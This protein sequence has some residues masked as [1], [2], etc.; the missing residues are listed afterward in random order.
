M[1]VAWLMAT[2]AG[3]G[4][5]LWEESFLGLWVGQRYYPGA[6]PTLLIVVMILQLTMIRV[7]SNIIDLTLNIRRKVLLGLLSAALSIALA[8]FLV[9]RLDLGIAGVAAGFI[10]GRA[11]QSVTYPLMIGRILTI[12]TSAQVAALVRAGLV[13]AGLFGAAVALSRVVTVETW[14]GLVVASVLSGVVLTIVA[15][16]G[17]LSVKQRT[18]LLSRAR[19]VIRLK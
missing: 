13:T 15:V 18:W 10:A 6:V 2:V 4:V 8:W 17:G 14:V 19:R 9:A 1:A 12:P 11:I 5:L 7:D 16:F 3:A